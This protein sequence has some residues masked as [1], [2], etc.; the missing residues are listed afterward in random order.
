MLVEAAGFAPLGVGEMI[1]AAT[2]FGLYRAEYEA[3]DLGSSL[4]RLLRHRFLS[5]GLLILRCEHGLVAL[6][7]R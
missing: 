6:E 7:Q 1:N 2:P 4:V 3:Q 5:R